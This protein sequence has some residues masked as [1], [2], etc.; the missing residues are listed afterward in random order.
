M[1]F[2]IIDDEPDD[3]KIAIKFLSRAYPDAEF[4][5]VVTEKQ[6]Y[7][8][9]EKENYDVVITDYHLHWSNGIKILME[10]K[11]RK[12]FTPV[13]MLTG[14]GTEEVAV[15]AMKRGLDDYVIKTPR[16]FERLSAVVKTAIEREEINR[17]EKML[18]SIVEHSKEAVVSVDREGR[19]IYAN[20]AVEEIFGWKREDLIGRH[21]SIMAVNKEEQKKQMEEAI[22]KGWA[23]FE[24]VRKARD[25]DEIP[26][27][28]TVIPFRDREGNLI[29]SSAIMVD[30]REQ[31]KYEEK[32]E[33][34]ND[35]LKALRDVNQLIQREKNMEKLLQ[36]IC[37]ILSEV[38]N[39]M[40]IYLDIDDIG[41]IGG[42]Q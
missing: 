31:K 15:E 29:F 30:I 39:Y 26:V 36:N 5:E 27:L 41:Y 18:S 33:H 9:L 34:L 7:E 19:I 23:R 8:S 38:E 35:L 42:D 21:M 28:M 40:G 32:L 1:K 12:P 37:H 13:I 20:R 2:L 4:V 22:R 17:K 14:T 11:K 24:T 25:G 3:R 16:H 6:F 10:I